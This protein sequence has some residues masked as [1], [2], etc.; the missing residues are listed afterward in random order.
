LTNVT[1]RE[2]MQQTRPGFNVIINVVV[3]RDPIT[4]LGAIVRNS[5]TKSSS[6][7]QYAKFFFFRVGIDLSILSEP[8]KL[9]F[10]FIFCT[11]EFDARLVDN[12]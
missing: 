3:H 6:S 11:S 4:C 10:Y 2:K 9:F 7:L 8:E 1:G 5:L 12:F